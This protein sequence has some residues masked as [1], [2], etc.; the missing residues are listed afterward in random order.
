MYPLLPLLAL[1]LLLS[2]RALH[3][4]STLPELLPRPLEIELALSAVPPHQRDGAAVYALE[5]G[6]YVPA[7]EGTNGFSC[8]VRRSGAVPG[9][10]HDALAPTCYDREGSGTL[11]PAV[12]DEVRLLEEGHSAGEVAAAIRQGWE[13][14]R[15]Q[16][17]GPGVAYMLSPV[18]RLNGRDGFYVP[19]IMFYGPYKT[20]AEVGSEA[21]RYGYMPFMQAPGTPAAMMVIP[22]GEQER[23]AIVEQEQ[24]LIARV[25]RYL[26]R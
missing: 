24:D 12:L 15:Y 17:P 20:D 26:K 19:H 11:L 2:P 14:G 3:G 16:V 5:R 13:Q 10:F 9:A 4:Q 25:A 6:G 21:D 8:L 1:L 23:A 22:A 7:R 18:F